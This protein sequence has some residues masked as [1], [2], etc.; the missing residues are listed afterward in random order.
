M[1]VW[2]LQYCLHSILQWMIAAVGLRW[3]MILF[4]L[5]PERIIIYVCRAQ[6]ML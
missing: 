6:V 4:A 3:S 2:V 5:Q 1:C